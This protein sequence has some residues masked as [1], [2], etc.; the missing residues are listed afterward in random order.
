MRIKK[1][2]WQKV[3]RRRKG[4]DYEVRR[5]WSG[6][7]EEGGGLACSSAWR[8]VIENTPV[9]HCSHEKT[10]YTRFTGGS[11]CS[12][13]WRNEAETDADSTRHESEA[14]AVIIWRRSVPSEYLRQEATVFRGIGMIVW[15]NSQLW[16]FFINWKMN[17]MV[18]RARTHTHVR[19]TSCNDKIG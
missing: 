7:R 6:K 11:K 14:R 12:G 13:A 4:K 15:K 3:R 9:V 19:T 5:E 10:N 16:I 1:R 2:R 17:M 8:K 18:C